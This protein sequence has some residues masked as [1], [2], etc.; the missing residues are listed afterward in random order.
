[1]SIPTAIKA[2]NNTTDDVKIMR[3]ENAIICTFYSPLLCLSAVLIF[4]VQHCMWNLELHNVLIDCATFLAI[5]G[6]FG[7]L[8][9]AK[10]NPYATTYIVS[11]LS[12]AFT[13]FIVVRYYDYVGPAIWTFCFI[14]IMLAMVRM[15]RVMLTF[16][17]VTVFF[18]GIYIT[19]FSPDSTFRME[20]YYYI[21]QFVL[22]TIVFLGA[23][24][25]QNFIRDRY[26]KIKLQLV[27][28]MEE[29][30]KR[31]EAEEKNVK[32]ALYDHMTGLP[33][34]V[35]FYDRLEQAILMAKR[36]K[37]ELYVLFLDLD[38]FKMINDSMGHSFGDEI[39]IM[40]ARR[41]EASLRATDVVARTGGDEFL[42]LLHGVSSPKAMSK[43]AANLLSQVCLPYQIQQHQVSVSCSIGIAK[44]P[45][46]G[47]TIEA[48][49]KHA[50]L[51]MYK[52]K[53][54]GRNKYEYFTPSLVKTANYEML[55]S[56]G[57]QSALENNELE[58]YYQPQVNSQNNEITGLE[59][60]IRWN[61]PTLGIISPGEFI[62]IAER[63]GLILPIGEW[64]MRTAC[65]QN[66]A[67]QDEGFAHIPISVNLSARQF[68]TRT[69]VQQ[70]ARL[71]DETGLDPCYL[72]LEIT[73]RMLINDINLVREEL[74]QLKA[75]GV[76][77]AI[78][79]FG[80]GYSSMQYLKDLPVDRIKI[81]MSFVQGINSNPRDESIISVIL[82]LAESLDM[83]VIAEGVETD[84]QIDFLR[85]R[86]CTSIQGF[87]YFKP[88]RVKCVNKHLN[89]K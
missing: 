49:V 28:V 56:N 36:N 1:M 73:E 66:K 16:I 59:S 65:R 76:R 40:V 47:D 43:I 21:V 22:F 38:L 78:D 46:D 11:A 53:G 2:L 69:L 32:L 29:S 3:Y 75:L 77:I 41:L 31:R 72:E 19:F 4:I 89:M 33:N 39:L 42:L 8:L 68:R 86:L 7:V 12:C 70:V 80:T 13:A 87:Y 37:T 62:P 25:F 5:G 34:R 71:L 63:N 58:L 24:L 74:E 55:L 6:T 30:E 88:M 52:A 20:D 61:H 82:A 10:L 15:N 18:T 81:P 48:L 35:L 64:V 44:Y 57:L 85:Q 27:A 9:K 60:L 26:M 83:D 51:A 50:D 17:G 67:W 23:L 45:D 14:E 54:D 84:E 79:D